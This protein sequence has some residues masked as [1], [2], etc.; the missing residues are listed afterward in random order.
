MELSLQSFSLRKQWLL[1]PDSL[2]E[3]EP[4]LLA[5]ASIECRQPSESLGVEFNHLLCLLGGLL[6]LDSLLL[7]RLV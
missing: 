3:V 1:V 4:A 7:R 6:L 5:G 2:E